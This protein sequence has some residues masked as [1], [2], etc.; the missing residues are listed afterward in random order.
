MVVLE[1]GGS[2]SFISNYEDIIC[3]LQC[4]SASYMFNDDK[5]Q[6]NFWWEFNE[7]L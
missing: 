6:L 4:M 5:V 7:I 2:I 3:I 1:G